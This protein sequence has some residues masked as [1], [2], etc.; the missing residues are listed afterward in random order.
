MLLAAGCAI[1]LPACAK[2]SSDVSEARPPRPSQSPSPSPSPSPPP[3]RFPPPLPALLQPQHQ[4]ALGPKAIALTIDDGPDPNWTP[5]MLQILRKHQV[6]A[7][8]FMLGVQAAAHPDLVRAVAADGHQIATHTWSHPNL[9]KLAPGPV[10]RQIERGIE[11]VGAAAGGDPP[12]LF[13]APYG[14]W[15]QA[16]LAACQQLGQRPLGWSVDPR[17]WARPGAGRIAQRVLWGTG[18]GS[19]ILTHDGGGDRSQSVAALR[20]YLPQLLG[21]GYRFTAL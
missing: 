12:S 21:Q 20:S 6:K 9:P 16:A 3:P 15:S 1:M 4:I 18:T 2:K 11:A 10:R 7:V 14:A 5:A 17:D 8:F 19:I 13:R